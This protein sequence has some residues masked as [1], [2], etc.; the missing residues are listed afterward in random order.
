VVKTI[1]LQLKDAEGNLVQLHGCDWSGCLTFS[2]P[3]E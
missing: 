2:D 1:S 3:P